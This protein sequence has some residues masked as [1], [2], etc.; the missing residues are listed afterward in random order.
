MAGVASADISTG[1]A[2]MKSEHQDGITEPAS[3]ATVGDFVSGKGSSDDANHA[4]PIKVSTEVNPLQ[5]SPLLR[6]GNADPNAYLDTIQAESI[7]EGTQTV[8]RWHRIGHNVTLDEPDIEKLIDKLFWLLIDFACTREE[9]SE[10]LE[11]GKK[12]GSGQAPAALQEKARRLFTKNPNTGEPG[13]LLLYFLAEHLLKYP[14]VLCKYPLKTNPNVHAH[15]AD[16]VHASVDSKTGHLRLHW[17]EAKLYSNIQKATDDCFASLNEMILEPVTAKK[18]KRRDVELMRDYLELND[19]ILEAAIKNYLDPDD[20]LS[21]KVRFCGLALIG[22]DLADYR[23]L[24]S[25]IAKAEL[26][27]ISKR[28]ADWTNKIKSS[29]NKHQLIGITIDA[30]CIPFHSVQAFRD[31]FLKRLG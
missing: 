18:T 15:G 6:D 11:K 10:A 28:V 29:V 27:G 25:E 14:Q 26:L 3:Q 2:A 21:K 23:S 8:V 9:L 5:L 7:I 19:P 13:E 20:V 1:N 24:T 16:G 30:F 22:F 4:N 31:A 17:G 12:T